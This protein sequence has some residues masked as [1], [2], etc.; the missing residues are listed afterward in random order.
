MVLPSPEDVTLALLSGM[1]QDKW[2]KLHPD[3]E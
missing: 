2:K 3:L 1:I